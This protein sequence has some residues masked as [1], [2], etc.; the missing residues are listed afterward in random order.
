MAKKAALG[1]K[2]RQCFYRLGTLVRAFHLIDPDC[3][4][5]GSAAMVLFLNDA[6]QAVAKTDVRRRSLCIRGD[7]SFLPP[8]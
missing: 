6:R 4:R 1:L 5:D 2:C 3:H 7:S 8:P